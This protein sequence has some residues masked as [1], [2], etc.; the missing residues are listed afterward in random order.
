MM[1][2]KA[3]QL[4]VGPGGSGA[5]TAMPWL[6]GGENTADFLSWGERAK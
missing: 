4:H 6:Q 1:S 5:L 3:Y 2:L